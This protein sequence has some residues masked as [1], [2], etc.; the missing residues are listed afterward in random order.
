MALLGIALEV[1]LLSTGNAAVKMN[2]IAGTVF[3]TQIKFT[4]RSHQSVR[5][6]EIVYAITSR[7]AIRCIRQH[8]R[9]A[10]ITMDFPESACAGRHVVTSR[11]LALVTPF[12]ISKRLLRICTLS[13]S[14]KGIIT[15]LVDFL[16]CCIAGLGSPSISFHNSLRAR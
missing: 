15:F 2:A 9:D 11:L 1:S 16:N 4:C 3:P 14:L 10:K 8:R 7:N 5:R 13:C 6:L 12:A